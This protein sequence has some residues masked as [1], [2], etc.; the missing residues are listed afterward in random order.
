MGMK[1]LNILFV[2]EVSYLHKPIFEIHEFPELLAKR[3]HKVSFIQFDEGFRFWQRRREPKKQRVSGRVHSKVEMTLLTPFQLGIPGVD[4]FL[5]MFTFVPLLRALLKERDFDVIVL[6]AVPTYGA[7]THWLAKANKIPVVFRA[8]DVSHKIRRSRLSL[9]IKFVEKFLY[10]RVTLIS[11]NNEGLGEYCQ[12]MGNRAVKSITNLPPLDLKHFK[13]Q[14]PD[15]ELQKSLGISKD[16]KVIIYMGSFFYFSG[17]VELIKSFAEADQSNVKL[18]IL[19]GGEQKAELQRLTKKLKLQERVIFTGFVDYSQ[20]P[21]YFSLSNV[22][23]NPMQQ[24]LVSN[25]AFPH[26]VLQYIA[27]GL[28]VVSTKL[29]GIYKIFGNASGVTWVTSSSHVASA[30]ISLAKNPILAKQ[31]AT[32]QTKM[33]TE[34][35]GTEAS[36]T[37]F[38]ESLYQAVRLKS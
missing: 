6:Y 5:A 32:S 13:A 21:K 28:P 24:G 2:H 4:R 8:I 30:A 29:D 20:L 16:D 37:S 17:L 36:L 22:A 3:G 11:A 10:S 15:F 34:I 27:A 35:L 38:E 14:E 9:F 12:K 23:V 18:L 31:N 7:Q 1:S 33:A 19:G 25:T 26:K